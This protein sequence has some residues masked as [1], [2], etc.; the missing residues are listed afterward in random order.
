VRR[1][2]AKDVF[3]ATARTFDRARRQLVP[4]FD[5]FYRTAIELIP[6]ASDAAITVLD[7]GAGTGL[8]ASF[9]AAA[10]PRAAITLVDVSEE[11]LA[12]AR[13]RFAGQGA[14]FQFHVQDFG[15]APLPGS[16]DVIV[17][18]LAIHHLS[19]SEKTALFRRI[20]AA[21]HA[22]GVFVNAEQVLG[23]TPTAEQRNYQ[24][25]LRQA[26]ERGVSEIDLAE[27]I[28]RRRADRTSPLPA[29]LRWLE[30]AG[31]RDVDCFYKNYM[32]AVYA[33]FK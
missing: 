4:C 7:L 3:D 9:V 1:T 29:Q 10:F 33:G 19:D 8:L 28:E 21:L 6:F 31:F 27:A 17:S 14:R 18:A 2:N 22:G 30:D 25:W 26:H 5:D 23:P 32:F 24:A 13:Q 16:Y 12:Q 20:H 15:S 11:M